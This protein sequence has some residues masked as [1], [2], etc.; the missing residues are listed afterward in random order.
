MLVESL[1]T[2][3]C[4]IHIPDRAAFRPVT[5]EGCTVMEFEPDRKALN[6]Y[7]RSTIRP[8]D[9]I[10]YHQADRSTHRQADELTDRHIDRST[11]QHVE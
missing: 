4:S 10:T 6:M 7:D 3:T 9:I 11:G 2:P 1:G 5:E 8:V